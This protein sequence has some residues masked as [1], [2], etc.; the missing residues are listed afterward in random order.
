[1]TVTRRCSASTTSTAGCSTAGAIEQAQASAARAWLADTLAGKRSLLIVDT[2]EQAAKLSAQI[3]AD[4]IRLGRVAE[5]G[6]PLGLQGTTAGVGDIV[7][8][9]K[10]QWDLAGVLGNRRGPINREQYRVLETLDDGGL[11]VTPVNARRASGSRCPAA[12]SPSTSRSATP[13]TVHSAQG[14]TVDTSHAVITSR[15]G[16][17]ALYVGLSRGRD[18]NTA[19]VCTRA[20]PDDAPTGTVNRVMHRDPI[21]VIAAAFDLAQPEQSALA[22]AAESKAEAESIRTPSELFVDGCEHGHR[23]AHRPLAR[24]ARRRRPPHARSSGSSWRPRTAPPPS[25]GCCARPSSPATTRGRS[26]TDAVT[27]RDLAGARQ[28]TNVIHHRITGSVSLDPTGDRHADWIPTVDD[29]AWRDYLTEL[30]DIADARRDELGQQVADVSSRSGRSRRSARSPTTTSNAPQWT[31]RAGAVAAHRELTGHDDPATAI[32]AA[33]QGRAGRGLRVLARRVARARPPR[34]RPRRSRDERRPTAHARPR[35]PARTNLGTALRRQRARRH[36]ASRRPAPRH[37]HPARHRRRRD[38]RRRRSGPSSSGKPPRPKPSPELLDERAAQLAEADDARAHWYAHT[39]AT[40][41]A[42]DRAQLELA[43]RRAARGDDGQTDD[44]VTA[45]EHLD[46][47]SNAS[48]RSRPRAGRTMRSPAMTATG[49]ANS[50]TTLDQ[51]DEHW[52]ITRR[53]RPRRCRRPARG[54]P[55]RRRRPGARRRRRNRAARHPRHRQ[56]G[57]PPHPRRRGPRPDGGR[58]HRRTTPCAPRPGRDPRPRSRRRAPRRRGRPHRATRPLA[59]ARP[60]RAEDAADRS[61]A[62]R[63]IRAVSEA[64][65]PGDVAEGKAQRSM[66]RTGN[67]SAT[68]SPKI[69][70]GSPF[71]ARHVFSTAAMIGGSTALGTVAGVPHSGRTLRQPVLRDAL[72]VQRHGMPPQRVLTHQ[73]GVDDYQPVRVLARPVERHPEIGVLPHQNHPGRHDRRWRIRQPRD[74]LDR[75]EPLPIRPRAHPA[76]VRL[77]PIIDQ[78]VHLRLGHEPASPHAT[79]PRPPGTPA[80]PR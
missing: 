64:S 73:A 51:H 31:Q 46:H 15:T 4:L 47:A 11:V 57:T 1:M 17:A 29:P 67:P 48:G 75:I 68:S 59:R 80:P 5:D 76:D 43:E 79:H 28:L 65:R 14:L 32:G 16:P 30:A 71:N 69:V 70:S 37:R 34:S 54:R 60:H 53:D 78:H 74:R 10:N 52:Q 56:R 58:D 35:L 77:V 12:T 38:H 36:P 27:S 19:H 44:R 9:R 18:A 22:T 39:A 45:A 2:N 23:R 66:I 40:R 7:Q 3:R 21:T 6:V 61:Y 13:S 26:S 25:T 8:A 20:V 24:R 63:A 55:P 72:D 42:A 49:A 41:A 62:D 33:A 50:T